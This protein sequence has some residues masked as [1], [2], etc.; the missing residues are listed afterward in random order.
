MANRS[1]KENYLDMA[2]GIAPDYLLQFSA[3]I[4]SFAT[5][6]SPCMPWSP[7]FLQEY[8]AH[9][10]AKDVWGV[11]FV[12]HDDNPGSVPEVGN[13][14][15]DDI[16]KWR[17]IVKAPDVSGFDW[18]TMAK[19]DRAAYE[20][21]G[22]DTSRLALLYHPH[23]GYFQQ[24]AGFMGFTG[25]LCAI[26]EEPEEVYALMD[27]LCRFYEEV[28]SKSID[29][30]RPDVHHLA[31]DT[32]AFQTPFMSLEQYRTLFKPFHVREARFAI[33]RGLPVAM[34]C[35]GKAEM[36]VDDWMD[37]N[38]QYWDPA[39]SCNDLVGIQKKHKSL[40]ITG[41]FDV[42]GE[43]L[44]P[45]IGEEKFKQAVKD[46]IDALTKNGLYI[47]GGG[48]SANADDLRFENQNRWMTEVVENYGARVYKG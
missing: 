47:F 7:G 41:G 45:E 22:I 9:K 27:Y 23:F 34:H 38:V 17:D 48:V 33:E 13:Y 5:N 19:K 18:E 25:A 14:M 39:Q 46:T 43:L 24:L 16:T 10:R 21:M 12:Q 15:L 29:Y 37:F 4:N 36:F 44:R 40:I 32:C 11:T 30:Y 28:V 26:Q 2:R 35:C 6:P 42:L 3:G 31:D 8:K 20:K 1:P